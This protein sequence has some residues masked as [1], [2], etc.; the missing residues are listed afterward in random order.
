MY[1][2]VLTSSSPGYVGELARSCPL[3]CARLTGAATRKAKG[4]RQ[5]DTPPPALP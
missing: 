2:L 4:H 1:D 3:P 5:T